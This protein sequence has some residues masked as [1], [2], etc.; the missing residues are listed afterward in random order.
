[1]TIK[2][3]KRYWFESDTLFFKGEFVF[4]RERQLCSYF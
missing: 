2:L 4:K 1:M 3:H